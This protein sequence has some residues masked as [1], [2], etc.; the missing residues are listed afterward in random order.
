[1][2]ATVDEKAAELAESAHRNVQL[3]ARV[4][5][6]PPPPYI[7]P[8][9]TVP[10]PPSQTNFISGHPEPWADIGFE[11]YCSDARCRALLLNLNPT[12]WIEP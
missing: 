4:R 1:M 8:I 3:G 5:P 7:R 12:R 11:S 6:P 10:A 2:Q 9:S